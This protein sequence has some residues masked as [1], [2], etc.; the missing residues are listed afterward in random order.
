ML[1]ALTLMIVG[2]YREHVRH[3]ERPPCK[4]KKQEIIWIAG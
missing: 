3:A 2:A 1:L 4:P